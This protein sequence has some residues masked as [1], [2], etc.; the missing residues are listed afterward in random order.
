M[1]NA[2]ATTK[3]SPMTYHVFFE[4]FMW[5]FL[6]SSFAIWQALADVR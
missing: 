1:Y 2:A 6:P 4:I 3:K 5:K